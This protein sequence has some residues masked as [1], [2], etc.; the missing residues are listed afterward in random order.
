MKSLLYDLR[1]IN[2]GYV[3]FAGN[4]GGKIVAEGKL[5]NG[6]VSFDKVNYI[7]EL[8]NNL[9]SVSQI[10]DKGFTTL[11]TDKECMI[12][13]QGFVVPKEWILMKAPRENDLYVLNMG[14]AST[15]TKAAQCFVSKATEK[16]SILWHRKMGHISLRKMN[17]L[18]HNELVNGVNLKNFNMTDVCVSCK[19][20]KQVKKSHPK[21][22]LNT[23]K[24]PLERLHMD[25]FGPVNVKS[26][27]GDNYCL[28]VTDDYS[29]FSW[30]FFQ[31][32]K[33]ETFQNLMYLF[34]KL[35]R[36]YNIPIRR[37]RSDNGTEFKNNLMMKYCNE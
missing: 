35:E 17:H 28:V 25:L 21:K 8:E 14:T 3:G 6:I 26:I 13:K 34:N 36:L 31:E 37:I 24:L 10:C 27:A 29:R 9:L 30:V 33:D 20:G 22:I 12:L 7:A 2:G 15:E 23:I 5:S 4:Q 1:A 18:V 32:R 19:K 16:E 11:F